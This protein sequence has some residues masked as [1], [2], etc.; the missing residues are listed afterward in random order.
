MATKKR[1]MES[2]GTQQTGYADW[3]KT[4]LLNYPFNPTFKKNGQIINVFFNDEP[5]GQYDF[6]RG[7]G[8]VVLED[9]N[10]SLKEVGK[11]QNYEEFDLDTIIQS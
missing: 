10:H 2:R 11:L 8:S 3:A 4:V 6:G 7:M 1:T 5:V 9:K